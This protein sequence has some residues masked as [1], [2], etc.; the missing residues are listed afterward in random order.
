MGDSWAR[1]GEPRAARMRAIVVNR[2][3]MIDKNWFRLGP[4]RWCGGVRISDWF[5]ALT[6][7][8]GTLTG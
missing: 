5:G 8:I 3:M 7:T 2:R 1:A 6:I 4:R